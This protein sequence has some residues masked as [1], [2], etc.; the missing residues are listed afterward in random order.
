MAGGMPLPAGQ[1]VR[2]AF[3]V[4]SGKTK[5]DVAVVD[6]EHGRIIT[7]LYSRQVRVDLCHFPWRLV[8]CA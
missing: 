6:T 3:D 8:R 1:A 4:G 2:A 7:T 5:M